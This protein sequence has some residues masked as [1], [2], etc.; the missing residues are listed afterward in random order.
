MRHPSHLP[1]Q[2]TD[3][4]PSLSEPPRHSHTDR[5]PQLTKPHFLWSRLLVVLFLAAFLGTEV[6]VNF[7][8]VPSAHAATL[9]PGDQ[10]TVNSQT[11]RNIPIPAKQTGDFERPNTVPE[12]PSS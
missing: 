4:M 5:S 8:I 3:S 9:P 1:H 12:T 6:L 2:Q 11:V 7:S 10:G